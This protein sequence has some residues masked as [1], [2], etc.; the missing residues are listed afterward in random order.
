M[1]ANP[2]KNPGLPK[3]PHSGAQGWWNCHAPRLFVHPRRLL[4]SGSEGRQGYSARVKSTVA[5]SVPHRQLLQM[6]L[7]SQPSFAQGPASRGWGGRKWAGTGP[8]GGEALE[9]GRG[10]TGTNPCSGLCPQPLLFT[11]ATEHGWTQPALHWPWGLGAAPSLPQFPHCRTRLAVRSWL[12]GRGINGINS[13][14]SHAV[15]EAHGGGGTCTRWG[16]CG[17]PESHGC[18]HALSRA[19]LSPGAIT[20]PHLSTRW[21]TGSKLPRDCSR[22]YG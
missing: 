14:G 17:I 3:L 8:L 20:G 22:G 15:D 5:I 1:G 13:C 16:A 19:L 7:G 10:R 9:R 2:P 6:A 18:T 21:A 11:F 12:S 4:D